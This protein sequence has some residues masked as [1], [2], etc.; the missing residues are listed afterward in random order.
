MASPEPDSPSADASLPDAPPHTQQYKS[1]KRKYAKRKVDFDVAMRESNSL[2]K[3]ELRIRE[4]SKRLKEQNDQLLEALLELN[5]TIRVPPSLRYDLDL[6]DKGLPTLHSPEPETKAPEFLGTDRE[7]LEQLN[8]AKARLLAGEL[9]PEHCRHLEQSLMQSY[10][11]AP[12]NKLSTLLNV[13][14]KEYTFGAGH[15][16]LEWEPEW[17]L[18]AALGYLTPDHELEYS[19]ALDAAAAGEV[20]PVEKMSA[21]SRE[22]DAVS[23]NPVSVINWLKKHKPQDFIQHDA[24]DT[25]SEKPPPRSTTARASK[26]QSAAQAKKEEDVYDDDGILVEQ[27]ASGAAAGSGGGGGGRGKRKRD[28]DGGYRPKGGSSGRARRKKDDTAAAAATPIT[29]KRPKRNS[30]GG[31]TA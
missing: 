30:A 21:A 24:G 15:H 17:E 8:G 26:R 20:Q 18:D 31:S 12:R 7:V 4:L 27:G 10:N 16:D 14:H 22:R 6:P 3:E 2:F 28:E 29:S 13:P 5:S 23:R 1:F 9:S 25:A 19:A 11:C